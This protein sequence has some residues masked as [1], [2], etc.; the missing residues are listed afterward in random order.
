MKQKAAMITLLCV[1][2]CIFLSTASVF[3][4][5][6]PEEGADGNAAGLF[7]TFSE[8]AAGRYSAETDEGLAVLELSPAFGRLFASVGL[9]FEGS[10]LYS[11]YMAELIPVCTDDTGFCPHEHS[12]HSFDL[13]I[14]LFS[15]M[16]CAGSYWPG[17]T[18]QRLTVMPDGI[19]LS[20]FSGSGYALISKTGMTLR[21]D[22]DAPGLTVYGPEYVMNIADE[23][24]VV[25]PATMEG[26][27]KASFFTD[28]TE[29]TVFITLEPDGTI[30]AL[31]DCGQEEPPLLLKGGFRASE[32]PDGR[33]YFCYLMSS[34]ASGLMPYS[35]CVYMTEADGSLAV[36]AVPAEDEE[37]LLPAGFAEAMYERAAE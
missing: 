33:F 5:G 1:A 29:T 28:G 32:E 2:V 13:H 22:D 35:G 21:R 7:G 37:V 27:R 17:E 14:R 3:A 16:S 31:Q 20:H 9:Y 36:M 12:D 18:V 34:P 4:G 6:I 8:N 30:C 15:N 24:A 11:Y 19:L 26:S 25:L 23:R 10:S